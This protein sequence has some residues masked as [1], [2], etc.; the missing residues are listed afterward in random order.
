MKA[1]QSRKISAGVAGAAAV[2]VVA[3]AAT[4]A[5][6]GDPSTSASSQVPA[7]PTVSGLLAAKDPVTGQL[8]APTAEEAAQLQPVPAK[9]T[10]AGFKKPQPVRQL[11]NG[12][13]AVTLDSSYEM[14][15]VAVKRPD[16]KV[17]TACV[18][19]NRAE[20]VLEAAQTQ[21]VVTKEVLDEK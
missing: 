16:G 9:D 10:K 4:M 21:P 19:A 18:P 6:G 2:F 15:S 5:H 11:A 17:V 14:A 12:T 20:A 7:D 1:S 8:R 13:F 3:V